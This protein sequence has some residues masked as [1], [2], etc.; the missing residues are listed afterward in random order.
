MLVMGLLL[1]GQLRQFSDVLRVAGGALSW[2][3]LLRDAGLVLSEAVVPLLPLVAAGLAYGRLR[4]EGGLLA[5]AA[6]G[7]GPWQSL[8]P[9]LVLGGVCG[10]GAAQIGHRAAPDAAGRLADTLVSGMLVAAS[11][12]AGPARLPGGGVVAPDEGGLWLVLPDQDGEATVVRAGAA[13]TVGGV[14]RLRSVALWRRELKITV[15]T[16]EIA[17]APGRWRRRLR[18]FAA[19][20]GLRSGRLDLSDP[21]H[22][23]VLHRRWAFAGL[24][25]IWALI[26]A[27]LGMAFGAAW[28][29]VLGAGLVAAA[30]GLL[31]TG[32]LSA[33]AGLMSPVLA[34]WAPVLVLL[35]VLILLLP[36]AHRRVDPG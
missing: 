29:T 13:Q 18:Q 21:H 14:L 25:P 6:L 8:A 11:G 34:A 16:A 10:V 31:R 5:L 7:V 30:Y 36:R 23:Y 12:A 32:E 33:R 20:N 35:G 26:G 22:H 19:P 4:A 17:L 27:C 28:G 3:P 1:A 15:D 9:A 24:A 2:G